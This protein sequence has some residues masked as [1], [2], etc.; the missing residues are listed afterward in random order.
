MSKMDKE[1]LYGENS[2]LIDST[3]MYSL[4][5][6]T[7]HQIVSITDEQVTYG[8][9]IDKLGSDLFQKGGENK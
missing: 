2:F 4:Y 8:V 5:Y 6:D 1:S 3:P 9:N 7:E